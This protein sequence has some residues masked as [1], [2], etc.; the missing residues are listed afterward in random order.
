MQQTEKYQFNLV[1]SGDTFSPAPLNDNME[2]VEAALGEQAD[3]VAALQT[4]IE[5]KRMAIGY[6]QGNNGTT[7]IALDFT[8]TMVLIFNSTLG[9]GCLAGMAVTGRAF[10][11]NSSTTPLITIVQDGFTIKYNANMSLNSSLSTYHYFALQ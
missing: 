2:K 3:Q 5:A 4:Q 11:Y 6:Y 7:N 8:P 10:N 9:G 1:E